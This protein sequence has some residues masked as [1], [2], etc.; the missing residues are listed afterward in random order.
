M[1]I[2]K[3]LIKGKRKKTWTKLKSGLYGWRVGSIEKKK[4]LNLQ[5]QPNQAE[6][7]SPSV[8]S[9]KSLA[10]NKRKLGVV[11][12]KEIGGK[13]SESFASSDDELDGPKTKKTKEAI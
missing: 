4:E 8:F 3:L 11:G 12:D 5:T 2:E 7:G 10:S 13:N 1:R 6:H 9:E